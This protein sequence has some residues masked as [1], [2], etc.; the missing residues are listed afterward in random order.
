MLGVID[1]QSDRLQKGAAS[2]Q[3]ALEINPQNAETH[4]NLGYC[5]SLLGNIKKAIAHYRQAIAL[6]PNFVDAHKNL[7]LALLTLGDL[8][9]G[10]IEYEWRWQST[11]FQQGNPLP[12]FSLWDGEDLLGRTLLVYCEQGL[13]DAIQF[14]RYIPLLLA[15]GG[16]IVIECPGSLARLFSE[17]EGI[18]I[19]KENTPMRRGDLCM[20][21]MSLPRVLDETLET[22]PARVPYL[23]VPSQAKADLDLDIFNRADRFKVGIVWASKVDHAT[24]RD[25]SCPIAKLKPLLDIPE[26]SFYSLQKEVSKE[27][28]EIFDRL[29]QQYPNNLHDLS[30]RLNDFAD[31]AAIVEHLDLVISVDTAVA[32]L[33][34]ALGKPTWVM[35]PFVSDW[36]W[37]LDREDSPWYPTMRLFRQQRHGDWDTVMAR[38]VE[39]LGALPAVNRALSSKKQKLVTPPLQS[40]T[41]VGIAWS[42]GAPI[43]W[44]IFGLNLALQILKTKQFEPCLLVEPF[45]G[46]GFFNPLQQKLLD[47]A[48]AKQ[49]EIQQI[50]ALNPG[51]PIYIDIPI[52]HALDNLTLKSKQ[53]QIRGK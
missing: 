52:L 23:S 1:I 25:R 51:R 12:P 16:N 41:E 11:A 3:K 21:L 37:M 13:G 4:S 10:F 24:S 45:R 9:Q 34:G 7:G 31:T 2:I 17:I 40:K 42:I 49:Q 27:E 48:I 5:H 50:V 44:G 15:R 38:L 35:L 14:S 26:I 53:T 18:N 22:I 8:R 39:A 43:G 30:D 36:R 32:H 47:P 19:A 33:A 29:L 6:N 20:P 46:E 28:R